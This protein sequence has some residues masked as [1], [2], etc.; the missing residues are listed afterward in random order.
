LGRKTTNL[1]RDKVYRHNC[2][3]T[4]DLF[5]HRINVIM[6]VWMSQAQS[7]ALGGTFTSRVRDLR[8]YVIS[9]SRFLRDSENSV[10]FFGCLVPNKS[11]NT[12]ILRLRFVLKN[13]ILSITTIFLIAATFSGTRNSRFSRSHHFRKQWSANAAHRINL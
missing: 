7:N 12:R 11:K 6:F 10:Y 9:N 1:E 2:S 3:F 5:Q 8:D 13:Q 4:A